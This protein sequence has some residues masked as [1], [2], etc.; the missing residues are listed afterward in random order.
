[1]FGRLWKPWFVFRPSQL[2]R[3]IL[4][5]ANPPAR[6]YVPLSTSWGMPVIADPSSVIGRSIVTT[7]VY[8]LAVTE[9]LFR[10][11]SPGAVVVD[12]GANIGYMSVLAGMLAGSGGRVISFEPHPDLFTILQRNVEAAGRDSN[13]AKYEII[14]AAVG[15]QPGTA[16]LHLPPGFEMN[17]GIARID[18]DAGPNGKSVPVQVMTLDDVLGDSK[19]DVLKMD[20][21][22][23]EPQVLRGAMR[24]LADRRIRHVVFEDLS[25]QDS[26]AVRILRDAGYQIFSLGWS[27]WGPEV[28]PLDSGSLSKGYEAPN[29]IATLEPEDVLARFK[30]RRFESLRSFRRS[31][32]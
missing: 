4:V 21:E 31:V 11:V 32:R 2:A 28:Q 7:G 18:P 22:G 1:V 5:S 17:D 16:Q 12:A 13:V 30:A 14:R 9:A 15:D 23:Y 27:M 29:F 8:D 3:R 10:L 19:V 25:V 26:E 20:V 6:G 24:S